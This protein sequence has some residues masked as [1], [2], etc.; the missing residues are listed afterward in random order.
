MRLEGGRC[1]SSLG[2][3]DRGAGRRAN[4]QT[5]CAALRPDESTFILIEAL[6]CLSHEYVNNA[7]PSFLP[8]K[9]LPVDRPVGL[10]D[11]LIGS[12]CP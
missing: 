11:S 9:L 10:L 4:W 2:G 12:D 7:R 8:A 1:G 3:Q 6:T 5:P